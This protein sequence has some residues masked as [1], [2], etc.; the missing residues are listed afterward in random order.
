MATGIK[1]TTQKCNWKYKCRL[2][3]LKLIDGHCFRIYKKDNFKSFF[4]LSITN[5]IA[6]KYHKFLSNVRTPWVLCMFM[7]FAP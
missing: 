5:S 2:Y 4:L 1:I 3:A 7:Y 6:K